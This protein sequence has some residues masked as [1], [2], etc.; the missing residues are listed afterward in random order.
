[1]A[2]CRRDCAGPSFPGIGPI[3]ETGFN[4][5]TGEKFGLFI[6]D[7]FDSIDPKRTWTAITAL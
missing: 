7:F 6:L 2:I 3:V 4:V 1:M 5:R